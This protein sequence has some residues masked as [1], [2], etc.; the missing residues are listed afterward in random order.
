MFF[1]FIVR[2]RM[3]LGRL[4]YPYQNE[5]QYKLEDIVIYD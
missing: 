4:Q 1:I 5:I 2:T 3:H